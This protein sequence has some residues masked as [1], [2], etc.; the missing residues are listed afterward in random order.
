L[1]EVI[2]ADTLAEG[3]S[4]NFTPRGFPARAGS[5]VRRRCSAQRAG[6]RGSSCCDA[7]CCSASPDPSPKMGVR[8]QPRAP[9]RPGWTRPSLPLAWREGR[10][11]AEPLAVPP[12][13]Q[14]P[15]G[16]SSPRAR[17]CWPRE[18]LTHRL[19]R[20]GPAGLPA[21]LPARAEPS[22]GSRRRFGVVPAA[23][24]RG[25]RP[26][27]APLPHPRP[28]PRRPVGPGQLQNGFSRSLLALR[29]RGSG[30]CAGS[31]MCS[32]GRWEK[33]FSSCAGHHGGGLPPT[34]GRGRSH[35]PVQRDRL[36]ASTGC[37]NGSRGWETK[38]KRGFESPE[39][40]C[41]VENSRTEVS[42][43]SSS[44]P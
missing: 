15:A 30:V 2:G 8:G 3:V 12:R 21:R 18:R 23:A 29:N 16:C 13:C 11:Q 24:R 38:E 1:T 39:S 33:T 43:L 34:I 14:V 4:G 10:V 36:G 35:A 32:K 41:S 42:P 27:L 40:F 22:G 20:R 9:Q 25:A 26:S 37:G 31:Q 17:G 5:C 7:A 19:R 28:V 44:L 6:E